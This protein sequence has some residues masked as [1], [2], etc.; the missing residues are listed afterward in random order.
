ME[1]GPTRTWR[2][3]KSPRFPVPCGPVVPSAPAQQAWGQ[4][5][6]RSPL[7]PPLPSP[8]AGSR[9][10]SALHP[11]IGLI[12]RRAGGSSGADRSCVIRLAPSHPRPRPLPPP[13]PPSSTPHWSCAQGMLR[14][15]EPG[16]GCGEPHHPPSE[17]WGAARRPSWPCGCCSSAWVS[18]R[19]VQRDPMG[20]RNGCQLHPGDLGTVLDRSLPEWDGG[21]GRGQRLGGGYG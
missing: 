7:P 18:G 1:P 15:P 11:L 5:H 17:T 19:R 9:F 21:R 4:G 16:L 6:S 13:P 8:P 12:R 14:A 3:T 20:R 2:P 10:P